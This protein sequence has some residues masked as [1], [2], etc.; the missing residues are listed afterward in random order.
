MDGYN[1]TYHVHGFD[2]LTICV[3]R[4]FS[5]A[6]DT[7]GENRS[8]SKEEEEEEEE[9]DQSYSEPKLGYHAMYVGIKGVQD[10]NVYVDVNNRDLEYEMCTCIND[11]D[12]TDTACVYTTLEQVVL[13]GDLVQIIERDGGRYISLTTSSP[14]ILLVTM[15]IICEVMWKDPLI[16][17]ENEV[18]VENVMRYLLRDIEGVDV[19]VHCMRHVSFL[20]ISTWKEYIES[21]GTDLDS[22]DKIDN[23]PVEMDAS[24]N[25]TLDQSDKDTGWECGGDDWGCCGSNK[26]STLD[27]CTT[28]NIDVK[29]IP[30]WMMSTMSFVE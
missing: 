14:D 30:V 12:K 11:L 22:K 23:D 9:E 25:T 19:H 8:I 5:S 27:L 29:S 21:E 28:T 15:D 17:Y 18:R 6:D 4:I 26:M 20:C 7:S 16:V 10:K 1:S 3:L 2:H 24:C 13:S